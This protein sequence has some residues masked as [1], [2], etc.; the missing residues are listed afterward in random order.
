MKKEYEGLN[1]KKI[2]VEDGKIYVDNELAHDGVYRYQITEI[3]NA[4]KTLKDIITKS[5][6]DMTGRVYVKGANSWL[7]VMRE[8][9]EEAAKQ[10]EEIKRQ[11]DPRYVIEG[12]SELQAAYADFERYHSDLTSMMDD[13][14]NDGSV[15]PE[16]IKVR[17]EEVEKQYP[18]AA[19]YAEADRY[20]C[21]DN[22]DKANAGEK[23]KKRII[24]GEN[25]ET[26]IAEM[27]AEWIKAA[28]KAVLNN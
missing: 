26:V 16:P 20:S 17:P 24:S 14:A 11:T 10:T 1:G 15:P 19:A 9:A 2:T 13:E 22:Y 18:R 23:A 12:Y 7:V 5:N 4:P 21:S 6:L 3:K 28:E 27:K 8:I 25:Y